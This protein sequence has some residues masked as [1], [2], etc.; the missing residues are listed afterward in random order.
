M[1]ISES[2]DSEV[3]SRNDLE[4]KLI[5]GAAESSVEGNFEERQRERERERERET[6][7]RID[8]KFPSEVQVNTNNQGCEPWDA[9]NGTLTIFFSQGVFNEPSLSNDRYFSR[10]ISE[11]LF[12]SNEFREKLTYIHKLRS[13]KL[14]KLGE[15]TRKVID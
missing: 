13:K 8:W 14:Q 15:L 4:E 7:G 2:Y 12:S 6:P 11:R 5:A 3:E 10:Y 9:D 1:C